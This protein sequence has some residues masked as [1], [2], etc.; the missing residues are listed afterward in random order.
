[1]NPNEDIL[2]VEKE[3]SL[4]WLKLN[5]PNVLNCLNRQLLKAICAACEELKE[6][7]DVHV[8]AIM[9]AGAKVFCAGADLSERIGLSEDEVFDYHKLIQ[10][11]MLTVESLPQ[12]VIAAM[13]GSAFGGGVELALAC[14]LRVIVKG[15]VMKMTEVRLGIIPGAGGT[16]RLPRL[17]G[18]TRAK[19]MI[20]AACAVDAQQAYDYGLVNR[21]IDVAAAPES[22][23]NQPLMDA[24]RN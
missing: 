20:L 18:K 19:E 7:K 14:D 12:C 6:E 11:T 13:N 24:V 9:G 22:S 8:I 17:I 2:L 10:Q 4:A 3:G 21:V 5:R 23:F 1:V 15:A 16:Q